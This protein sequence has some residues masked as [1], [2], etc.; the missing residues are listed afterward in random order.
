MTVGVFLTI[1]Y[2]AYTVDNLA[3]EAIAGVASLVAVVI[4]TSMVLWM[5]K[6]RPACPGIC[7]QA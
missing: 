3:A 1:Q 7:A 5:R 2:S 6:R 4:V